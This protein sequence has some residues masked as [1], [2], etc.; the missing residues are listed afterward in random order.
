[1]KRLLSV[2]GVLGLTLLVLTGCHPSTQSATKSDNKGVMLHN[3][4]VTIVQQT[5]PDTV[6]ISKVTSFS[7]L[8]SSTEGLFRQG[9]NGHLVAGLASKTQVSHN[10]TIYDFTIRQNARWSNG[11]PIT[12]QD[13]VYSWKRTIAKSTHSVNANL[14]A[15]IKNATAIRRGQLPA[16]KLG[17]TA[18]SAHHL[19]VTLDH[20]IA[21]FKTLLAY[22]YSPRKAKLRCKDMA[23]GMAK[24]PAP[25]CTVGRL[26]SSNGGQ[27]ARPVCWHLT[28]TTGISAT[29]TSTG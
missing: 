17:V 13:F 23:L 29:C 19:R 3:Q 1:M 20:P 7:K 28:P 2:L 6:D 22:P 18:V 27:I 11:Q 26:S 14:F 12:A 15:G 9:K 4:N 5:P 8:R 24:E 25:S 16:S 21:Y 10:S